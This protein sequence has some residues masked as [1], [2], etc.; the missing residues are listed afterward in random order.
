MSMHRGSGMRHLPAALF[1]VACVLRAQAAG[2]TCIETCEFFFLDEDC[3]TPTVTGTWPSDLKLSFG[4]RCGGCCSPPGGPMSCNYDHVPDP[5][6]MT[7]APYDAAAYKESPPIEGKFTKTGKTCQGIP[8]FEFDGKLDPG[9][10]V[11]TAGERMMISIKDTAGNP[12]AIAFM[13]LEKIL[14]PEQEKEEPAD[15]GTAGAV[16]AAAAAPPSDVPP[17]GQG[18]G[19]ASCAVEASGESDGT[20][21]CLAALLA[22]LT[23]C[24]LRGRRSRKDRP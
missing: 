6:A 18:G 14:G 15:A 21:P 10:Y 20:A 12:D 16:D 2:A 17:S 11:L 13:P 8:V 9:G 23:A 4:V 5:A 19:C 22:L 1:C 24:A 7:I 3:R